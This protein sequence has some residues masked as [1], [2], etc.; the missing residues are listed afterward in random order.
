MTYTARDRT[1]RSAGDLIHRGVATE[2]HR[3][4]IDAVA[5]RYAVAVTPEMLDLIDP[6]N[7]ADPIA[8]QFV[9]SA[10]EL[11][12]RPEENADPI[13][14]STHMPVKGIVHRYPDR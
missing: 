5:E 9:P 1:A 4:E 12:T 7:P 13:G 11:E 2:A 8:R 10:A 6:A 14:D 3:A